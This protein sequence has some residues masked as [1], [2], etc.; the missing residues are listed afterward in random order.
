MVRRC[1]REY[2]RS[3]WPEGAPREF[4]RTLDSAQ[5]YLYFRWLGE[6]PEWTTREK[7]FW[8]Y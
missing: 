7:T 5:L 2:Q 4:G 1:E 6:R 8:R 3:R